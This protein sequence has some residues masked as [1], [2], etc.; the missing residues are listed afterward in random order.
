ML[1]S[2]GKATHASSIVISS[3]N[4]QSNTVSSIDDVGLHCESKGDN[5]VHICTDGNSFFVNGINLLEELNATKEAL[6]NIKD[7]CKIQST[8]DS[9]LLQSA[10]NDC[11]PQAEGGVDLLV[12]IL[13]GVFGAIAALA[14][15]GLFAVSRL[16]YQ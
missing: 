7:E 6:A 10:V 5:S 9:R 16:K 3:K 1:G 2:F 13:A 8:T 4:T 15:V 14:V 11:I 12:V